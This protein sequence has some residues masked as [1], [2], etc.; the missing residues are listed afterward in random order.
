VCNGLESMNECRMNVEHFP[1]L[2]N[3]SGNGE[4]LSHTHEFN[5]CNFDQYHGNVLR[6]QVIP[7]FSDYHKQNVMHY[8]R[9]S[10]MHILS[11]E[12]CPSS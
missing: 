5:N 1:V 7:K 12:A 11:L 9:E 6:D 8:L 10:H 4:N 2:C 3:T